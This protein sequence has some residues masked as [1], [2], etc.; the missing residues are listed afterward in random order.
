MNRL[1]DSEQQVI[2]QAKQTDW[3]VDQWTIKFLAEKLVETDQTKPNG[4]F[5]KQGVE[6]LIDKTLIATDRETALLAP[7]SAAEI[8]ASA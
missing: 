6:A 3:Q 1:T 2:W 5:L 8:A 4:L 7:P